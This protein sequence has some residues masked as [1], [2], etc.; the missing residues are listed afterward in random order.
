MA[1]IETTVSGVPC[2]V[3]VLDYEPYQPAFRGGPLDSARAPGGGCGVWAVLDRRGRPAPWLEAKLTDADV[4]A[5]E[6]LVFGEME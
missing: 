2:I 5:I 4:E 1:E 3:G 6:E